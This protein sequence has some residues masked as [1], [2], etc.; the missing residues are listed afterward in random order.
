[1]TLQQQAYHR[2]QTEVDERIHSV[3]CAIRQSTNKIHDK[4]WMSVFN[5]LKTPTQEVT[6][7]IAE[8]INV[9]LYES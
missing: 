9:K 8:A 5:S 2:V 1:M 4:V 3:Y 7:S 6:V